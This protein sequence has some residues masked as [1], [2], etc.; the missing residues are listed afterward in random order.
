MYNQ[1]IVISSADHLK[2]CTEMADYY[3]CIPCLSVALDGSLLASPGLT[4]PLQRDCCELLPVAQ[5]LQNKILFKECLIHV[6]GPWSSPRSRNLKDPV[7][8]QI[9][10]RAREDILMKI[11][12][13]QTN[14][15]D[16]MAGGDS[17]NMSTYG[18]HLLLP[19]VRAKDFRTKKVRLPEYYRAIYNAALN[20]HLP[21]ELASYLSGLMANNLSLDKSGFLPGQNNTIYAACFLCD[22]IRDEDLPWSTEET[23]Q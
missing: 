10:Q 19:A 1:P 2:I 6:V 7:L 15:L 11:G 4:G 14:L 18:S 22:D 8:I 16:Q 17:R 5:K 23:E 3:R 20:N 12:E 21:A 9:A 13:F